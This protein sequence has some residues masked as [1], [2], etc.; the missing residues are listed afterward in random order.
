[1]LIHLGP[2]DPTAQT[3]GFHPGFCWAQG[4]LWAGGGELHV[5]GS[6]WIGLDFK[7]TEWCGW[8][9]NTGKSPMWLCLVLDR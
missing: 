6:V 8:Q 5:C 9:G 2:K 1:M 7:G 3:G 4:A